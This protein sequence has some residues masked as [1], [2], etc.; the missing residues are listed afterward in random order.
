MQNTEKKEEENE[1][2][3]NSNT[4]T[5]VSIIIHVTKRF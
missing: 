1:E 2:G 3:R 4:E 5:I